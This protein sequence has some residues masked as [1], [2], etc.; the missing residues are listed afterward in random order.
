MRAVGDPAPSPIY[1]APMRLD[2]DG[3]AVAHALEH[4]VVGL[5]GA[6]TPP[7]ATLDDAIAAIDAAQGERAARR[8]QRF[9]Q[10]PDD[11]FV[12]TRGADGLYRLGRVAGPWRYDASTEAGVAGLHHVRPATWLGRPFGDDVAPAAVAATFARGCRNFQRT[13]DARA[14]RQTAALWDE[15]DGAQNPQSSGSGAPGA[16]FRPRPRSAEGGDERTPQRLPPP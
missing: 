3:A 13:H 9:A 1:R 12:W 11:A 8:L 16:R 15:A 4:R 7:P 10:V 6:L 2:D 5:P 14:E